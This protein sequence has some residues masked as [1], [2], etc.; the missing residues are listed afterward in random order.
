MDRSHMDTGST[1]LDDF[2]SSLESPVPELSSVPA[3]VPPRQSTSALIK[4]L[5]NAYFDVFDSI[6]PIINRERFEAELV[7]APGSLQV[8]AL[9]QA[10]ATLGALVAPE[11]G[12]TADT[13][14]AQTRTLLEMCEREENGANLN[15]I[16]TLH[17]CVLLGF[18]ELKQPNFARAWLTLGRGIRLGKILGFMSPQSQ[19][20]SPVP[21]AQDAEERRRTMWQLYILD[22]FAVMRTEWDPAFE[23][24]RSSCPFHL[25]PSSHFDVRNMLTYPQD[26]HSAPMPGQLGGCHGRL[27]YAHNTGSV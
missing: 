27:G 23:E 11:L 7:Q 22:A 14:Y 19:S 16:N 8:Q 5:H 3:L 2:A 24:V 15:C 1:T 6:M 26:D 13:S 9:S 25:I 18:Y 4:M 17:A 10:M 20:A 12:Y 21:D